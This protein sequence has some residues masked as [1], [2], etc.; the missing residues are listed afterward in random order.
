MERDAGPLVPIQQKCA[1]CILS[2]VKLAIQSG[3]ALPPSQERDKLSRAQP[4][5]SPGAWGADDGV[6]TG[7]E[8]HGQ[9][10]RDTWLLRGRGRGW[11][12]TFFLGNGE[13]KDD[14][15]VGTMACE[16]GAE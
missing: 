12:G 14:E 5:P 6:R 4:S 8:G 11:D 15:G 3:R 7:L 1:L 2:P 16:G 10:W 9:D 13:G